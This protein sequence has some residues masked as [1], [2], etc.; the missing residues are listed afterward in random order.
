MEGQEGGEGWEVDRGLGNWGGV[1]V[2]L[3]FFFFLHLC[4]LEGKN[5]WDLRGMSED[6]K[7][8]DR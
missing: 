1:H 3:C 5:E 6:K 2:N 8:R 4:P 7:D